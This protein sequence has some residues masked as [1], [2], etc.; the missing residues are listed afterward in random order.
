MLA[1]DEMKRLVDEIVAL[2]NELRAYH[3]QSDD[4]ARPHPAASPAALK[5]IRKRFARRVPPSYLQLLSLYDGVDNLDWVD[6]S[7]LTTTFL[8]AHPDQDQ[9]WVQAGNFAA[10]ERFIFAQS[11]SDPHAIAFLTQR[12]A[13][14]EM[15]VIDFDYE[16]VKTY[17]NLEAYLRARRDWFAK[18][19]AR[20]KAARAGLSADD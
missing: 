19:V 8:L 7:L 2:G 3:G 9:A 16:V 11:N 15:E 6:V 13:D 5:A 20:E 14:G 4:P 1:A 12:V 18:F 10:G 17:P